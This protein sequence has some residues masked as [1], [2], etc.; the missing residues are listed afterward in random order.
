MPLSDE[1]KKILTEIE[2]QLY[3]SDPELA[4]KVRSTTVYTQGMRKLRWGVLGLILGLVLVIVFLQV[5]YLLSF[6][7]GFVPMLVAT[8]YIERNLRHMG[9]AGIADVTRNM[10]ASG[11]RDYF[12]DAGERARERFRRQ[13]EE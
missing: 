8:W 1:E 3:A 11:L 2:Q 10:K 6:L 7:F 9:R 4:S 5:H 13:D 12:H